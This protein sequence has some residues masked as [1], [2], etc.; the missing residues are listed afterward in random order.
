MASDM[1]DPLQGYCL[2][3]NA[4]RMARVM[5]QYYDQQ[6]E[7]SGLKITQFGLMTS[8]SR[9]EGVPITQLADLLQL[10]RTTL[11]RNLKPLERAG[12]L[13][14]TGARDRRSR[15]VW[16]TREGESKRDLAARCWQQAQEKALALPE[17]EAWREMKQ[18]MTA[19]ADA[20]E[21]LEAPK[22]S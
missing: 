9:E 19:L 1:L 4:R 5:T 14:I 11:T 16:L 13:T 3:L 17:A 7:P 18:Q 21:A 8:L 22:D 20:V 2:C 12:L 15:E 6:L 10:D